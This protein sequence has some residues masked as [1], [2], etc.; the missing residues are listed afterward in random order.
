[1]PL[2]INL[3]HL[4][5][6]P[7][8]LAGRVNVSE[9]DID[10]HDEVIRVSQPVDYELEVQWVDNGLL[11]QGH[12]HLTLDCQCVRCLKPFPYSLKL[13]HWACHLPLQGEDAVAVDNDCVDL[14]P[15]LREDILLAFPQHPLC[16]TECRGLPRTLMGN[17]KKASNAGR[18]GKGSSAWAEL[19][20]LK[21]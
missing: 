21:L 12:L 13:D 4:E 15:F 9:L 20:K 16:N 17:P 7:V 8:R 19:N 6:C 11:L 1:M 5:S 18:V 2:L 14:T 10:P 3:R